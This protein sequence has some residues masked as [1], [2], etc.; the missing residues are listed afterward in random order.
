MPWSPR[1][2]GSRPPT[3][4]LEFSSTAARKA[5]AR[6]GSCRR[7]ARMTGWPGVSSSKSAVFSEA[8]SSAPLAS[9]RNLARSRRYFRTRRPVAGRART[10]TTA[11]SATDQ[12]TGGGQQRAQRISLVPLFQRQILRTGQTQP[13]AGRRGGPG[14]QRERRRGQ[15]RHARAGP[16]AFDRSFDDTDRDDAG[17]PDPQRQHVA[18]PDVLE[19]QVRL[20]VEEAS[21]RRP[22]QCVEVR[23]ER[24]TRPRLYDRRDLDVNEACALRHQALMPRPKLQH[25][26]RQTRK[27]L[28]WSR[29]PRPATT[30]RRIGQRRQPS[31]REHRSGSSGTARAEPAA[32]ATPTGAAARH[33]PTN[34]SSSPLA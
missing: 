30:S 20:A 29:A 19:H 3:A 31:G 11:D 15:H 16:R 6:T 28:R 14:G 25:A 8:C 9:C 27:A 24:L 12:V 34:P 13:A 23:P 5:A 21:P 18:A 32:A 2:S 17:N 10:W 22:K 4:G 33:G 26:H 1:R 7:T